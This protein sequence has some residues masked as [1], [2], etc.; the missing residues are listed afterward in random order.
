[1]ESVSQGRTRSLMAV[2]F[3]HYAGR[4]PAFVKHT[5]LDK[6]LPALIARVGSQY[7]CFVYIDGFAGPW[8]SVAGDSFADTSFGIALRHMTALKAHFAERGRRVHMKAILVEKIPTT[9]AALQ[10]AVKAF[11][12]VECLALK[13]DLEDQIPTILAGMPNT[14]FSFALIDPKGFPD[15]ERIMPLIKRAQSEALVNF[16]FDFA[17]RFAA[18]SLIPALE[19]WLSS[20]GDTEWQRGVE[21]LTGKD[22]EERLEALAVEKLRSEAGYTYSPVISVDKPLHDRT[23]YKLIFLTRHSKGLQVFRD[24]EN[25]ALKAQAV[26]RSSAKAGARETKSGMADFFG[27]AAD[28]PFDRSSLNLSWG[29]ESSQAKLLDMIRSGG[30]GGV[31]WA[32]VWPRILE[33]T[34]ITH[35]RLGRIANDLRKGCVIVAPNWP[36]ERHQIPKEDQIL[37]IS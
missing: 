15:V 3:A 25:A 24:S 28:V 36:S 31:R 1:M 10:T 8:K 20:D 12:E 23:L 21:Q 17:N 11:P 18:T 22:R 34:V 35:S 19:A 13:G 37:L 30:T 2:D 5:F 32:E 26:S 29:E 4:E 33:T 7:D 14:A 9:F 6:Y 16:M 27:G